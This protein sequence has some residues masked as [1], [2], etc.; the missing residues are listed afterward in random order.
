MARIRE[1][2]KHYWSS[3]VGTE[4]QAMRKRKKAT[5]YLAGKMR[6]QVVVAITSQDMTIFMERKVRQLL[7]RTTKYMTII[8][9]LEHGEVLH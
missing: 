4:I 2:L 6:A 5:D 8:I 7:R 1:I 3:H 9:T